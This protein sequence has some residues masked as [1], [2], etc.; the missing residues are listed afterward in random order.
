MNEIV[1]NYLEV[2]A[3]SVDSCMVTTALCP[4]LGKT[5]AEMFKDSCPLSLKNPEGKELKISFIGTSPYIIY[6]P[7]GGSEV[8]LIRIFAKKFK[9]TPKFIPEKSFDI[10]QANGKTHGMFHRVRCTRHT[11][12]TKIHNFFHKVS[13]K[14]SEMGIGQS[15]FSTYRYK[16]V[17]YLPN[18][19]KHE[20]V[21]MSKKPHAIASF[22]T[23]IYPFD[24]FI[25][26]FTLGCMLAEFG[27][28]LL[29]QNSWNKASGTSNNN[30]H[31]FEGL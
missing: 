27:M 7:L 23:I 18:M 12:L 20:Y 22:D 9:F 4:I 5:H 26:I 24:S 16:L 13:I 31:V 30:N 21:M 6:D 25:W 2:C 17:D 15:S 14:E 28:L 1:M 11:S 29:M 3:L 10:V 8:D 19:Y